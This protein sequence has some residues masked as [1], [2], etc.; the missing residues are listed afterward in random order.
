[1]VYWD[2]DSK[3][4]LLIGQADG[5]VKIFL[6]IGSDDQPVFDGGTRVKA[7]PLG[8]KVDIKVS[9]RATL[10]VSDWDEDGDE[11]LLVGMYSGKIHL[12][13]NLNIPG[14][15][16]LDSAEVLQD[17]GADLVVG[18]GRS[19][20]AVVDLDEDGRKD[21]LSGSTS[22]TLV[23]FRNVGTDAAPI[24][25]GS[26]LVHSSG[27]AIDLA[28]T[29]RSRP[30]ACDWTGD[31]RPDM[32]IGSG[33]GRVRLYQGLEPIRTL[34]F[35]DGSSG[36]CPCGNESGL[37]ASEGCANSTAVGASLDATGSTS[38]VY[39]D[40]AL[41][42]S[43]LPA[44]TLGWILQGA[45]LSPAPFGDG[46]LCF[47]VAQVER[48]ELVAVDGNGDAVSLGSIAGLGQV[49]AG[50]TLLYQLWYRDGGGPCGNASNLTNAVEVPWSP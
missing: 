38:V 20:P 19:S 15:P 2:A 35:G 24:F 7:G 6:N 30:N 18:T 42:G 3:K 41:H 23:L 21:L 26:E 10:E 34:C 17:G 32:L 27:A 43:Q 37:G 45:P 39:D 1:M 25:A 36:A 28:G 40:L 31:G 46:I 12:Y 13:R 16:D 44:G 47:G 33:D 29:P 14:S 48:L 8:G 5:Y 49:V 4:D 50:G 11:D 22:G 9:A